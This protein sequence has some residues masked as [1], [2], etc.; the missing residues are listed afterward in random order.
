[1]APARPTIR[2]CRTSGC[3]IR[4]FVREPSTGLQEIRTYYQFNDLDVDRY[5]LSNQVAPTLTA[6]RELNS[7][8]V[9]AGFVN[10][11]MQYTHGYGAVLSAAND[12]GSTQ[13]TAPRN[14]LLSDIPPTTTAGA[15]DLNTDQ[16]AKD[17]LRPVGAGY[18]IVKSKQPELDYQ[19]K[20]GTNVTSSYAGTGGVPWAPS[21]AGLRSPFRF[22]DINR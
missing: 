15:P 16:G 3:S 2:A 17:L 4:T 14:F 7:A 21:S 11:H 22:G 6:I 18:V 5:P 12:Q 19:D 1:V 10:K 8:D 9:P 20:N 13:S